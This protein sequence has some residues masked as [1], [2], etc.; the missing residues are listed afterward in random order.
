MIPD[1]PADAAELRESTVQVPEPGVE[2]VQPY[3]PRTLH[4]HLVDDPNVQSWTQDGTAAFV[5]ISG[6]TQLSE[7]LA[8]K[9]REGAEQIT[10]AIGN[11]FESILLVAY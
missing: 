4:Q 10:D 1:K 3:V 9:G 8:R 11:S 7:Q 6:F 2:R 5:D